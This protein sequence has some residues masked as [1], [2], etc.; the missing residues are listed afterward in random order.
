MPALDPA[1]SAFSRAHDLVIET[2]AGQS[3]SWR[4]HAV[5]K[6][7]SMSRITAVSIG[8]AVSLG[9][10][11][12][13]EADNAHGPMGADRAGALSAIYQAGMLS[14]DSKA[15]S[16]QRPKLKIFLNFSG[17][18]A[19]ESGELTDLA[20][21]DLGKASPSFAAPFLEGVNAAAR[22]FKEDPNNPIGA[23]VTSNALFTPANPVGALCA[24]HINVHALSFHETL[25]KATGWDDAV[26]RD[27]SLRHEQTHCLEKGDRDNLLL[28]LLKT[29]GIEPGPLV[30]DKVKEIYATVTSDMNQGRLSDRLEDRLRMN[31]VGG[32][33]AAR[34]D[35]VTLQG[36]E[37]S[38]AVAMLS[39]LKESRVQVGDFSKLAQ[40]RYSQWDTDN[41]HDSSSLLNTIRDQIELHPEVLAKWKDN[42]AQS[43][44]AGKG[45]QIDD[46]LAWV[47]PLWK[48]HAAARDDE[49]QLNVGPST[50]QVPAYPSVALTLMRQ[51][52]TAAHF[53]NLMKPDSDSSPKPKP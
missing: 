41:V 4:Q 20:G 15:W 11:L 37:V 53:T 31:Y 46:L 25:K 10:A 16:S 24:V 35:M 23:L 47:E 38:D 34:S 17:T 33:M 32:M 50:T 9:P 21:V 7:C 36:E 27:F 48:A 51:M 28:Q 13:H 14:G 39:L 52:K 3:T 26:V 6:I 45:L 8:L 5:E 2:P 40:L 18:D 43:K 29:P 49:H 30:T 42:H 12:A 1:K 44:A 19:I 22:S